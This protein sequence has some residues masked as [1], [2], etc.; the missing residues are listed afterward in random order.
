M[1]CPGLCSSKGKCNYEANPPKCECFDNLD[2][3]PGCFGRGYEPPVRSY[4][5][6]DNSVLENESSVAYAKSASLCI[7]FFMGTLFLI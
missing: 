1:F 4:Y 5:S 6:E 3:S 2:T 7:V